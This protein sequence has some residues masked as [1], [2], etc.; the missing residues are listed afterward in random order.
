M[1]FVSAIAEES[2]GN[3]IQNPL[4]FVPDEKNSY[5][6]EKLTRQHGS[7]SRPISANSIV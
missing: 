2:A 3:T 4:A 5:Y 6:K 1:P 7:I